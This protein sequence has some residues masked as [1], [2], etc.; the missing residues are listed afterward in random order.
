[1]RQ[2]F[3]EKIEANKFLKFRKKRKLI[4]L[5]G[6][7]PVA[8]F[9]VGYLVHYLI[10]FPPTVTE[11]LPQPAPIQNREI[12]YIVKNGDTLDAIFAQQEVRHDEKQMLLSS[13]KGI[14]NAKL[15]QIG[16][17]ISFV[18]NSDGDLVEYGYKSSPID[19]YKAIK[20]NGQYD[21]KK[22]DIKVQQKLAKIN[23]K[24]DSSLYQAI[25]DINESQVLIEKIVDIF[26]WD[27]DFYSDP[28]K[29][30]NVAILVE[31]DFVN[32]KFF[33]YGKILAAEYAGKIVKQ[34]AVYYKK[35][36]YDQEGRSLARNFLKTPVKFTRISSR[37]G[38][39][40]HPVTHRLKAHMGT[41]YAAP[42][43]ASV[44]AM[45]DGVVTKKGYGEYNGN[46]IAI[47]HSK[48]YETYYLHLSKFYPGI[49][50]GKRV[51]QKEMIGYVGNTGRS[52][53]PHLHLGVKY[54][55]K[56]I[57]PLGIK[58][59]KETKLAGKKLADFKKEYEIRIAELN[60]KEEFLLGLPATLLPE[61]QILD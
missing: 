55:S 12:T 29:G 56:Y 33:R 6:L 30:D 31:K 44:W 16:D 39:R 25:V 34:T 36:Y 50:K 28:R 2:P 11:D 21:T 58:K 53:G 52:T 42:I 3:L 23:V 61:N 4:L 48:G 54:H 8:L 19:A 57:D 43:G 26:A 49:Y 38:K 41:D 60:G 59:V 20:N 22:L 45:A 37:F 9:L 47:K 24:L 1:M 18:F 10:S 7:L 13:F 5:A 51:R 14:W 46:Y 17:K 15:L 27:I 40:K 35:N 32:E